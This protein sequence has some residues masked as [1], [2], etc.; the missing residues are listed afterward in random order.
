MFTVISIYRFIQMMFIR[1][2]QHFLN[3]LFSCETADDCN[4]Q[5]NNYTCFNLLSMKL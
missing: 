1:K 2:Q 4:L 3:K 5:A